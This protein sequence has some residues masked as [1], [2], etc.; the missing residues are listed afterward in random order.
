MKAFLDTSVFVAA[1]WGD[2]SQ[3]LSSVALVRNATPKTAFCAAHTVAEV[4]ST[5]T[6][7]P[8]K[9]PI[10]AEQALLFIRQMRERFTVVALTE[11]DYFATVERLAENGIAKS[12]I[13]DGLIM[14]AAAKSSADAIYTWD[15]DDFQRVSP[16]E[17]VKLI[18]TP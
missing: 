5:M 6:R 10:P 16:P 1:F 4:Y 18:R 15:I 7:L 8:V 13:F 17:T 3:H 9:P 14:T 11:K 2:H 12:Y